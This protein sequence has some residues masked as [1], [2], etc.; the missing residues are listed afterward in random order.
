MVATIDTKTGLEQTGF[1]DHGE[2]VAE[3]WGDTESY[4]PS[5]RRS[6][7]MDDILFSI[8]DIGIMVSPLSHPDMPI[9]T[10]PLL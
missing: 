6:I 7:V 1:V 4:M 5:M 3:I 8:S 2:L 9:A 10:V